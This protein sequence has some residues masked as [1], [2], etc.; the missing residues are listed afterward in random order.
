[1]AAVS[2]NDITSYQGETLD[3][4]FNVYDSEDLDTRALYNL[5]GGTAVFTYWYGNEAGVDINGVISTTTVTVTVSHAV[6]RLLKVQDY[7]YQLM[8]KNTADKV[9]MTREG[10]WHIKLS[11]NPDAVA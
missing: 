3:A 6:T 9:V 11:K 8:C 2:V 10:I 5:A 7:N 4:V 1:M